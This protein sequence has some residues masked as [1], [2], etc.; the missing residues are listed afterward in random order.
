MSPTRKAEVNDLERQRQELVELEGQ[1]N[2]A[3]LDIADLEK[4]LADSHSRVQGYQKLIQRADAIQQGVAQVEQARRR[5]ED[6]EQ[7]RTRYEDLNQEMGRLERAIAAIRGSL[8]A[9]IRQLK[10]K[11]DQELAPKMQAA[12]ALG[13]HLQEAQRQLSSLVDEQTEICGSG[14][15]CKVWLSA[16]A[17]PRTTANVSGK[18]AW[19]LRRNWSC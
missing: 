13:L 8:E 15:T 5:Y 4:D 17:R 12:A 9:D 7:A 2:S 11:A 18:K 16:W 1:S 19:S 10:R 3:R 14:N 6:L